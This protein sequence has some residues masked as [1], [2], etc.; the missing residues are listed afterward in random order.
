MLTSP[1]NSLI[2]KDHVKVSVQ[3]LPQQA[4][5]YV[6]IPDIVD[7]ASY[8]TA[9]RKALATLRADIK[10]QSS[11]QKYLKHLQLLEK[12]FL[13]QVDRISYK[14]VKRKELKV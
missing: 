13:P 11:F 1:T 8:A 6:I 5:D 2:D 12:W 3:V 14:K 9:N 7:S 10:K 4:H